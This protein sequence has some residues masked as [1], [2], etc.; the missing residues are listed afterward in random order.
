MRSKMRDLH[1]N[2][3]PSSA[4]VSM[5]VESPVGKLVLLASPTGISGVRFE[6]DRV[7]VAHVNQGMA[8][9]H[10][11]AAAFQLEE[12]FAGKR[13]KFHLPLDMRGTKFQQA[14]WQVTQ[15]V[16]Y[17]ERATYG[18]IARR[19]GSMGAARAV[20]SALGANPV[21]IIVPC[22]RVVGTGGR[23]AGFSSGLAIK[24]QLLE[25]EAGLVSSRS[26]L[27]GR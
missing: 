14:V 16:A 9:D 7:V 21:L 5:T 4:T 19:I 12:Y 13:L 1:V 17:A 10:L 20:G 3:G 15:R 26:S 8:Q 2:A 25:H 27:Y 24:R 6:Q 18:D 23:L 22:H 11:D